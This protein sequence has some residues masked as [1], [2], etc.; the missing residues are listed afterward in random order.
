MVMDIIPIS[1]NVF[2]CGAAVL[3]WGAVAQTT[4]FL[5]TFVCVCVKCK[6]I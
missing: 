1:Q 6:L 4:Q 2:T 3:L 5:N